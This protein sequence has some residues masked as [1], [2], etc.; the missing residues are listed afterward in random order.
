MPLTVLV[1]LIDGSVES[2]NVNEKTTVKEAKNMLSELRDLSVKHFDLL[3]ES[4]VLEDPKTLTGYGISNN[5]QLTMTESEYTIAIRKL[6]DSSP[7][8]TNLI[9]EARTGGDL[10]SSYIK[11]GVDVNG[12]DDLNVTPLYQACASKQHEAMRVLLQ[13]GADPSKC[14]YSN[15]TPLCKSVNGADDAA[16]RILLDGGAVFKQ[17]DS[18]ALLLSAAGRGCPD[19]VTTLLTYGADPN[20][21]RKL[22]Y[23]PLLIAARCSHAGVVRAL[24]K[25]GADVN[26]AS[27]PDRHTAIQIAAGSE[28]GSR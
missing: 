6:G 24:I 27:E 25:A 17:P 5:D 3:F 9:E 12:A 7:T 28:I 21:G 23:T 18:D 2:L 14:S 4:A 22:G 20:R 11:A 15:T 19:V 10:I 13:H 16:V 26:F 1:T 8:L